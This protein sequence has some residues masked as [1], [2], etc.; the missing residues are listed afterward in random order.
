MKYAYRRV[1]TDK[2]DTSNQQEAFA[3]LDVEVISETASSMKER[4][5]LDALV[6]RLQ[7]G[8]EL[9]VYALDRLGRRTVEVLTVIEAVIKKGAAIYSLREGQVYKGSAGKFM[10]Q[11][12]AA[13]AELERNMISERT[14]AAL[15]RL[16]EEGVKLGPPRLELD[17]DKIYRARAEGKSLREIAKSLG[18]SHSTLSRRLA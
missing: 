10:T 15:A 5:E 8:D 13:A 7:S 3:G 6:A 16:K 12:M 18:I 11:I 1:S 14:K 4:P 17:I 2:Q 9:Y